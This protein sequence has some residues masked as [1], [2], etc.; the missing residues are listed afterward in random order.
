MAKFE[1]DHEQSN[2]SDIIVGQPVNMDNVQEVAEKMVKEPS[3]TF[4][5]KRSYTAEWIQENVEDPE[6]LLA[7][8]LVLAK[9]I[10]AIQTL[11]VLE[12][13]TQAH[14][15]KM[16]IDERMPKEMKDAIRE[17][18]REAI[19]GAKVAEIDDEFEQLRRKYK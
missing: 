16:E 12:M 2:L 15:A 6:K 10:E 14:L 13:Q 9:G 18:K 19:G 1:F 8:A 4:G 3:D 11:A 5:K 7:I 17:A